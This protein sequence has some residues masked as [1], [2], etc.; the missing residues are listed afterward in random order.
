MK[1]LYALDCKGYLDPAS[2]LAITAG[3]III[4]MAIKQII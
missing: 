4:A 1:L 2:L 3:T